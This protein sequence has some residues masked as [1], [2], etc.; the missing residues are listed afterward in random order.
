MRTVLFSAYRL[1][2]EN[3]K[4]SV[5]PAKLL[6]GK[7]VSDDRVRWLNQFPPLPA[8]VDYLQPEPN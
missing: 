8:K 6:K 3:G 4:V 7:N 1:G 2:I 5:N